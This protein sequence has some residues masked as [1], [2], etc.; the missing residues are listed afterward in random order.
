MAPITAMPSEPPICREEFSTAEPTPA[1]STGTEPIA[2]AVAGVITS[3]M[4]TPPTR[5]PGRMFQKSELV[6]SWAKITSDAA[7]SAR[8][9]PISQ[10]APIESVSFPARGAIRMIS[11]V[12]GRKIAPVWIAE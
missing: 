1:L 11:T 6:S 2:A 7:T 8:P 5:R 4:P 3:A 9:P 10:R 12:I